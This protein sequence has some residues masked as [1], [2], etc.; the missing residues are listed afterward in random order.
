MSGSASHVLYS[1][2][3]HYVGED[4]FT[5]SVSSRLTT[6]APALVAI[7]VEPV[8]HAPSFLR[9]PDL[10]VLATGGPQKVAGWATRIS[11]GPANESSQTVKFEVLG[12]TNPG[13][14]SAG[15]AV[16]S[17]GDLTFAPN[18]GSSG[19][20]TITLVLKD[21]GGTANGGVDTSA[22]Q[23]FTITVVAPPTAEAQTLTTDEETSAT[24]LLAGGDSAGGGVSFSILTPPDHGTLSPIGAQSCS[25]IPRACQA[26]V[27]YRPD[28]GYSGSDSFTYAVG[29]GLATSAPAQVSIRVNPKPALLPPPKGPTLFALTS[30]KTPSGPPG[31]GLEL[32][33]SGYGCRSIYFF[34]DGSRIGLAHP[35]SEG[36][37]RVSGLEIPGDVKP[38]RHVVETSCRLTGKP[39]QVLTSFEVTRA[40][41]HRSTVMTS[42]PRP[43]DVDLHP[44]SLVASMVGVVL[45]LLIA[46][47]GALLD[48]TLD[49]HYDEVRAWFRAHPAPRAAPR[50]LPASLRLVGL[51]GFLLAGGT[52]GALLDPTFGLNRSSLA[53]SLGLAVSLGLVFLAFEVPSVLYMRRH[54]REWGSIVLRPG[55][56]IL[57]AVL[58][59]TSRV[60]HLQPGFLV[61]VL[62]GLVFSGQLRDKVEGRL[63]V[64]TSLFILT[65][66]LA[67]WLLWVPAS[68]AA[69]NPG[70]GL[71]I[72]V[73]EAALGGTFIAGLQSLVVGLLPLREM[74]G[75]TV[76][77]WSIV[78]WAT[79]YLVGA[80]VYV[81]IVL[82][83]AAA[84]GADPHGQMWKAL[85]AAGVFAVFAL[86]FWAFFRLRSP[87]A[88]ADHAV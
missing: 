77:S 37:V 51:L 47:P 55:A 27:A 15:P 13:L 7:T 87:E 26:G 54:N 6:S 56:L 46:F 62:G 88:V 10:T 68:R 40:A 76:K 66:A 42:L 28:P 64:A 19:S 3:T 73:A 84:A 50:Q 32:S 11:A 2:S 74:D 45:I 71:W 65:L 61:G 29:N 43:A 17:S 86:S 79:V 69:T 24:V 52:A 85:F 16:T 67:M 80:F 59:G 57:T 53:L 72:I 31:V 48:T 81:L 82:R 18:P 34:F 58:V 78:G 75:S 12:N 49:E 21:N 8:N 4:A 35:D 14:L 41:L 38:G 9:G 22:P 70:A 44:K 30:A 63:A 60:L 25:G 1:P 20:T 33:G 5:F 36:R 23:R 39:A 83:P